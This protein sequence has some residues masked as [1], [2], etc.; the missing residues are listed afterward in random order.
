MP[1]AAS[2]I[3][4]GAAIVLQGIAQH[5]LGF[6]FSAFQIR[7]ILGEPPSPG[8]I[9]NTPSARPATDQNGVMP[10]LRAIIGTVINA[11]PDIVVRDFVGDTG[12]PHTGLA[13]ASPGVILGPASTVSNR[14]T[15]FGGC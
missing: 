11:R 12:Q 8:I 3:V 6:R 2:A 13:S 1:P 9:G 15:A 7:K 14:H 10:N 4:A 5:S